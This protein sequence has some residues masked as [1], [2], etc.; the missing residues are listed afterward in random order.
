MVSYTH[1]DSILSPEWVAYWSR[2]LDFVVDAVLIPGRSQ[3]R[4]EI[5]KFCCLKLMIFFKT[6]PFNPIL[7]EPT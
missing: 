4:Q 1:K 3:L 6:W 2:W 5:A 7:N